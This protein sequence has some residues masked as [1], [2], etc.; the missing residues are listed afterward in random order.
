MKRR[1]K[2]WCDGTERWCWS[3]V[4]ERFGA[5]EMPEL[6]EAL[7]NAFE[8]VGTVLLEL[9]KKTIEANPDEGTNVDRS[10]R[11]DK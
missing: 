8:S 10:P 3:C 4:V 9:K 11:A 6:E 5:E 2:C 1:L 7:R